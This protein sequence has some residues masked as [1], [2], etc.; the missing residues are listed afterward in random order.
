MVNPVSE[1][2]ACEMVTEPVPLFVSDKDCEEED[3]TK[4]LAKVRLPVLPESRYVRLGV[5]V[6]PVPFTGAE[7]L[8]VSPLEDFMLI[9]MSPL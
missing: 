8:Y 3:P 2:V 1:T 6:L 4:A 9:T 5:D 7:I